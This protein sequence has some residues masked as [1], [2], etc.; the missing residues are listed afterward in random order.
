MLILD[1]CTSALDANTERKIQETLSTVLQ[2]KTAIMVSQ[3]VSMAMLCHKILVLEN[4]RIKEYG[5]H[6]ELLTQH[7]FYAKLHSQQTE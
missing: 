3:R 7:G 1:D 2:H 4:G 5:T 6:K